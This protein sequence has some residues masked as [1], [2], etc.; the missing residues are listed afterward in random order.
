MIDV[1]DTVGGA[2]DLSLQRFRDKI[3]RMAEDGHAHLVGQ[4]QARAIVLEL[5]HHA[6]RLFI[7]PE[8]LAGHIGQSRLSGMA[9]RRMAQIVAVG[10]RLGQIL[11]EPQ[12]A[13]DCARDA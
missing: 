4:I 3:A 10:R 12:A 7:V 8:G 5:V 11:I 1:S 13:A 6:Q 2:D 9:E